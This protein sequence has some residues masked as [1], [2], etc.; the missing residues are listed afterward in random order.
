[1]ADTMEDYS[2][3]GFHVG[4][5]SQAQRSVIDNF[6]ADQR[7][8]H[9]DLLRKRV[10]E[11]VPLG[12]YPWYWKGHG[13]VQITFDAGQDI[14]F[15]YQGVFHPFGVNVVVKSPNGYIVVFGKSESFD[16][17]TGKL[18]L[19][20][21]PWK[22]RVTCAQAETLL[23]GEKANW[24]KYRVA[25]DALL[26][27]Y[28][29]NIPLSPSI[30]DAA[31][32][33]GRRNPVRRTRTRGTLGPVKRRLESVMLRQKKKPKGSSTPPV[34]SQTIKKQK[35][36]GSV[37]TPVPSP[38][39]KKKQKEKSTTESTPVKLQTISEESRAQQEE[40][41]EKQRVY[42]TKTMAR[43]KK[44]AK[45][46]QTLH[47]DVKWAQ[48]LETSPRKMFSKMI[49]FFG[50]DDDMDTVM[51]MAIRL[52]E[53]MRPEILRTECQ[54]YRKK[55]QAR[56]RAVQSQNNDVLNMVCTSISETEV[57]MTEGVV[58][59]GE[60]GDIVDLADTSEDGS[61][62][63]DTAADAKL[64]C[65][66][67]TVTA[68]TD[69]SDDDG[70]VTTDPATTDG[71]DDDGPVA[72]VTTDPAMADGSDDDGPV[73][74]VTTDTAT[75]DGSDVVEAVTADDNNGPATVD[76]AAADGPVVAGTSF[77]EE[78][79]DIVPRHIPLTSR[80]HLVKVY[81]RGWPKDE[82]F[83]DHPHYIRSARSQSGY[84]HVTWC[85]RKG[86][87]RVKV[88]SSTL[89]R[90]DTKAQAC[91]VA[92]WADKERKDLHEFSAVGTIPESMLT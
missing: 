59:L 92:Y 24:C 71:S 33:P 68:T 65:A 67:T 26:K 9:R 48:T 86:T 5:I 84:K 40:S 17:K 66:M 20:D 53:Q 37:K 42:R 88:N 73:A 85:K 35:P 29:K 60:V 79:F 6:S 80:D 51:V 3:I 75:T 12:P 19:Q 11:P 36:K 61:V 41:L 21:Q 44:L 14:K 15:C 7:K 69:G 74:A 25:M 50:Y 30:S 72:A 56:I 63:T 82:E 91:E 46:E 45:L 58:S 77:A 23:R 49:R 18:C 87:W 38:Q 89:G 10:A 28:Q 43:M 8:E 76:T 39:I 31:A 64:L 78:Y 52:T 90:Y 55:L 70:P 4:R 57:K 16:E 32:S 1:M 83:T 47:S 62:T 2:T 27:K 34:P 81:P 13:W 54:R 22:G